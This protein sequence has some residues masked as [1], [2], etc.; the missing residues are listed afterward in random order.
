M[1]GKGRTLSLNLGP[2]SGRNR[3]N[4]A[5]GACVGE[6]PE[7]TP[8]S[9]SRLV[10]T[11]SR[12]RPQPTAQ[13]DPEQTFV[14]SLA[15]RWVYRGAVIRTTRISSSCQ[16]VEQSLRLFQIGGVELLGAPA[17]D[18]REEIVR[19]PAPALLAPQ[20]REAR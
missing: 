15:D 2:A 1:C 18:W 14:S 6:G 8:C 3:C 12:A 16:L 10:E 4:L 17:I 9:H 19:L 20:P 5:V 11:I 7:S 13:A